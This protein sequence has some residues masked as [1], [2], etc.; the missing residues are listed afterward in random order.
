MCAFRA[1]EDFTGGLLPNA[2][3]ILSTAG[4]QMRTQ[5]GVLFLGPEDLQDEEEDDVFGKW[6]WARWWEPPHNKALDDACVCVL[7]CHVPWGWRGYQSLTPRSSGP[8]CPIS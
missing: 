6:W 3:K 7:V 2:F 4:Y 8:S 5:D 1:G